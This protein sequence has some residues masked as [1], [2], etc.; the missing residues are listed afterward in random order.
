MKISI[1]M[2]CKV[3][4]IVVDFAQPYQVGEVMNPEVQKVETPR[5]GG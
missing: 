2:K 3:Q 4:I 1:A 5:V